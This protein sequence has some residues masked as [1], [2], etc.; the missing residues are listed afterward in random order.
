MKQI[1]GLLLT[2]A[3]GLA[4]GVPQDG[5]KAEMAGKWNEAISIYEKIII[6]KPQETDLYI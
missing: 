3:I 4:A 1:A 5:L 6:K 2:G